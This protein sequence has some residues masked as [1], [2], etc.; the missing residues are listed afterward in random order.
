MLLG[1]LGMSLG[2]GSATGATGGVAITL[3]TN[4]YNPFEGD[5]VNWIVATTGMTSGT[6]YWTA[7]GTAL[8]SYFSDGVSSGSITITASAGTLTRGVVTDAVVKEGSTCTVAIRYGSTGG[9]ILKTLTVTLHD[10]VPA[11]SQIAY[12]TPGTYTWICPPNVTSVSVVCVGG[13][14]SGTS[15][16]GAANGYALG[17]GGGGGSGDV[18]SG[19]TT[20]GGGG[21]G[22]GLLGRGS[23]G[24]GGGPGSE[25][26][27]PG[28]TGGSGGATGGSGT[29]TTGGAGGLYGGGGAAEAFQRGGD[30]AGAGAAGAVRII[31]PG[32]RV[33]PSTNTG[34]L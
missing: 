34:N 17:G 6:L 16:F 8:P 32:T 18:S 26:S 22:V 1:S 15:S 33:F 31:W 29:L 25:G 24:A 14:A 11:T 2:Y 30:A 13:G 3:T 9:P 19:N 4:N 5:N 23:D 21:G 28:G 27:R 10:A 7:S 12:T 20:G